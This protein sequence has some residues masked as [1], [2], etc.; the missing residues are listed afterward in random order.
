MEFNVRRE[1]GTVEIWLTKK[2]RRDSRL[3]E[4]LRALYQ[5][6]R[7]QGY[8]TVVFESG[9]RDLWDAASDLLCYNRKRIAQMEVAHEK[10]NGMAM[11]M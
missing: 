11:G 1:C 4:E 5:E 2:E 3:R 7:A 9:E 8:L 10:Q 6:Y